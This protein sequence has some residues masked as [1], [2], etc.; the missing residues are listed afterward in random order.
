MAT[1]TGG[2]KHGMATLSHAERE[3]AQHAL[4]KLRSLG[5]GLGAHSGGSVQ[6]ATVYSGSSAK[7]VGLGAPTLIH[8]Q[9][10][11]TFIGGARN[12][13]AKAAA[14]IG[15]DTV[16]SGSASAFGGRA[17]IADPLGSHAAHNLSLSSDTVNVAGLTAEA[18]K[19]AHP[20]DAVT[21]AHTVTLA[22]KTT[23]TI[24]GLS[25]QDIAKLHHG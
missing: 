17:S 5:G 20:H 2:A 19:A 14:N 3:A 10:S 6:S 11:D 15:R 23:V 13:P 24:A 18:V 7:S 9:G 4:A 1:I 22:D 21:K 25:Q 8:G 12:A 16:V